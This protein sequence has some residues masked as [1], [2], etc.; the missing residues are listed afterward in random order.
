MHHL[1][2]FGHHKCASTSM[3]HFCFDLANY[4]GL[5]TVYKKTAFNSQVGVDMM[6]YHRS[7]LISLNSSAEGLKDLPT[8]K[9]FHII[10]DPRDICVSGYFSHLYSHGLDGF[11]RLQPHRKALQSCTKDEGLLM[12]FEFSKLWL[13]HMSS[14]DYSRTDIFEIKMEE[15]FKSPIDQWTAILGFLGYK[16][17]ERGGIDALTGRLNHVSKKLKINELFHKNT[18]SSSYLESLVTKYSFNRLSAGRKKGEENQKSHYRKGEAGD[19][20]NHFNAEHKQAFKEMYGDLLIRL[21]YEKDL[22]W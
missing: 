9:G 12:E 8:F 15:L 1:A 14:W 16:V 17:E 3:S 22:N 4:L 11:D 19:W 20:Q 13:D 18:I 5:P 7:F 6:K 2:F 10:R 21:G